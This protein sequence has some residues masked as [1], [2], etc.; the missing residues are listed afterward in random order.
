M[1]TEGKATEI[2][3]KLFGGRLIA[4]SSGFLT[5]IEFFGI[6][7][8]V[9]SNS[10]IVLP[11]ES[12]AKIVQAKLNST[13]FARRYAWDPKGKDAGLSIQQ[14][15]V[16]QDDLEDLEHEKHE[17]LRHLIQALA[18]PQ[19]KGTSK[20]RTWTTAYFFPY[21]KEL[22]HFDVR[23]KKGTNDA[24]GVERNNMR[25]AGA[26]VHKILRT[27]DNDA[28]LKRNRENLKKILDPTL[29]TDGLFKR[30]NARNIADSG[31]VFE[32]KI[33]SESSR[34]GFTSEAVLCR[35]VDNILSN[36]A[37]DKF[38]MVNHL[39]HLIPLAMIC[40]SLR[41]ARE[42][43]S[44]GELFF[45]A[46]VD[47]GFRSSQLRRES[48]SSLER[49]RKDCQSAIRDFAKTELT[50]DDEIDHEE[51]AE[52]AL[53]GRGWGNYYALTAGEIGFLNATSGNRH[54]VIKDSLL[55]ALVASELDPGTNEITL[56]EFCARLFTNWGM[57][58]DKEA[59]KKVG[60]LK[61]MNGADFV[62]N[63]EE[64]FTKPLRR[65]G[66]LREFSDQTLMVSLPE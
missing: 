48:K 3:N 9:Y 6:L 35:A 64:H 13:D 42:I 36:L 8:G 34:K 55:E 1:S 43:M 37:L 41:A 40:H 49:A 29:A 17:P 66:L 50:G 10:A 27:D 59:A 60:L 23:R 5:P 25:G 45:S 56:K 7:G 51:V 32:D 47:F 22:M 46:I 24:V 38:T 31:N 26:L 4:S 11:T 62:V 52:T 39:M 44:P 53:G 15:E 30:L 12:D 57:V 28:R 63:A 2:L 20:D 21:S 18:I 14:D 65:L 16:F 58:I 19:K 61:R 54:H 33:E